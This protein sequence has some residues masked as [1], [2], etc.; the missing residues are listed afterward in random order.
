[1]CHK[2]DA[3]TLNGR[4][5][6]YEC[7]ERARAYN[8]KLR[9]SGGE[10]KRDEKRKEERAAFRINNRCTRCGKPLPDSCKYAMCDKHRAYFR[11]SKRK[12]M[13]RKRGVTIGDAERRTDYGLCFFCGKPVKDGFNTYG[14][15]FKVCE[16]HY[17]QSM[18]ALEKARKV[19]EEKYHGRH[20]FIDS[21][22]VSIS[23]GVTWK[24]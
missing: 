19:N 5:Y 8:Q 15:K 17:Q 22:M 9:D 24:H 10:V 1:M 18:N 13:E 6:C 14:A 2:Q 11:I 20:V 23:R 21:C 7:A 3:Y 12:E 16:E 4:S